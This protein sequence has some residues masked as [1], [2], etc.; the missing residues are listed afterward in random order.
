MVRTVQPTGEYDAA[1]AHEL[2]ALL[3]R[4]VSGTSTLLVDLRDV[5]FFDSCAIRELYVARQVLAQ[6]GVTF[7]LVNIPP[8]IERLLSIVG[9]RDLLPAAED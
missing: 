5:T 4:G 7:T 1:N 3:R 9:V 2:A 6:R 8:I